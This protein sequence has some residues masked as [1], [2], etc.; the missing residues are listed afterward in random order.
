MSIVKSMNTDPWHSFA[1]IN[2]REQGS[3]N[4][5]VP[6]LDPSGS[7]IVRVDASPLPGGGVGAVLRPEPN[8]FPFSVLNDSYWNVQYSQ[9]VCTLNPHVDGNTDDRFI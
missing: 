1:V 2:L 9:M 6:S 3:T 5:L 4:V 7:D 8:G